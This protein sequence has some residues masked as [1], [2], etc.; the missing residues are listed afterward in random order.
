MASM[1]SQKANRDLDLKREFLSRFTREY[2]LREDCVFTCLRVTH[3]YTKHA[4]IDAVILTP[5][6]ILVLELFTLAGRFRRDDDEHWREDTSDTSSSSAPQGNDKTATTVGTTSSDVR[7]IS[8]TQVR[9]PVTVAKRKTAALKQ[10]L[11][12][13]TGPRSASDFDYRA[14]LIRGECEVTDAD[15][16][17]K[18]L[19]TYTQ[20]PTSVPALVRSGWTRWFLEK[21]IPGYPIWLSG[22]TQLKAQL[23]DLPTVDMLHWRNDHGE[24]WYGELRKCGDIP[25][26]RSN[27]SELSFTERKGGYV[28]GRACVEVQGKRRDGGKLFVKPFELPV[29]S[30]LEFLCVDGDTPVSVKLIKVSRVSLSKPS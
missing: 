24:S 14:I 7:T 23:G 28:Y 29:D 3:D 30:E 25:Y 21:L 12:S 18:K 17:H 16:C 26:N 4:E 2:G 20:I 22:Y 11:E 15:T 8:Y 27:V 5:G 6:V 13:K 19:I 10:H 9:N 1:S